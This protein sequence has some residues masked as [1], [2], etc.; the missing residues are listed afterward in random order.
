M[1]GSIVNGTGNLS[2]VRGAACAT[3]RRHIVYYFGRDRRQCPPNPSPIAFLP[4]HLPD[5]LARKI[6]SENARAIYSRLPSPVRV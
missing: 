2:E 6:F 3:D 4:P 1:H 5:G